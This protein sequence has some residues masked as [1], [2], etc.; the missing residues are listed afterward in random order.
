MPSVER[1]LKD[2]SEIILCLVVMAL[3]VAAF[4]IAAVLMSPVVSWP[5]IGRAIAIV[6]LLGLG[7]IVGAGLLGGRKLA[8]QTVLLA[9][10]GRWM[11][12][13]ANFNQFDRTGWRQF[14]AMHGHSWKPTFLALFF[15]A[16]MIFGPDWWRE[17]N[18]SNLWISILL[19]VV[20]LI[21]VA[22]PN[23]LS[24]RSTR[25]YRFCKIALWLG[26]IALTVFIVVLPTDSAYRYVEHGLYRHLW[27]F[28]GVTLLI[29]LVF[30]EIFA[31]GLFSNYKDTVQQESLDQSGL[32][33]DIDVQ[34]P[35][36]PSDEALEALR[37]D[38]KRFGRSLVKAPVYHLMEILFFLSL[39]VLLVASNDT[40][41]RWAF[42]SGLV[43]W[44]LYAMGEMHERLAHLLSSL[45]RMFFLGGQLV[46]SLV[47]IVLAT[48]RLFDNSYIATVVEGEGW[49]LLNNV[50]LLGYVFS[51]YGVFWLYEYWVNRLL[52]E[53]LIAVIKGGSE[54]CGRVRINKLQD[55]SQILLQIHGGS[56][57]ACVTDGQIRRTYGRM[58]LLD[59]L[60]EGKDQANKEICLVLQHR[61]R[62]YF[63]ALSLVLVIWLAVAGFLYY[64]L[65]QRAEIEVSTTNPDPDRLFD[66]RAALIAGNQTAKGAACEEHVIVLAASGGGTRAALYTYSVLRGLRQVD[67]EPGCSAL[68]RVVLLSGVSGGSAALAYFKVNRQA[69]LKSRPDNKSGNPWAKFRASMAE[70]FIQDVL[71]GASEMR[72]LHGCKRA[73]T[74]V[75]ETSIREGIR[76]SSLLRESFDRRLGDGFFKDGCS[77]IETSQ[78]TDPRYVL[79]VESPG[80][81][82]GL[83]FNSTLGGRF[84]FADRKAEDPCPGAQRRDGG[85]TWPI[86][87]IESKFEPPGTT[88][89]GKGGR[90]VF[91]NLQDAEAL[92]PDPD[93]S[94][95]NI[96]AGP[97]NYVVIKDPDVP[98]ATAAALSA[99]FP[100]V[101]P[102]AAV[103][104]GNLARYWVTDGG[105]ADNRGLV[106]LLYAL[107]GAI[108]RLPETDAGPLPTLHILSADAS[109]SDLSYAQDRG[110]G[111]ALGAAERFASQL[112]T[113][114]LN[115][116]E[117]SYKDL[118]S[119]SKVR[120]HNLIMPLALRSNGGVGTHWMLPNT[121]LL[122][123]PFRGTPQGAEESLDDPHGMKNP[124][125]DKDGELKF[126]RSVL[127][128][129][130]LREPACEVDRGEILTV[131]D[132]L[133]E[134]D[135]E[136][137]SDAYRRFANKSPFA[138]NWLCKP[139]PA[140]K[141]QLRHVETWTGLVE[142]L[143]GREAPAG[144]CPPDAQPAI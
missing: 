47:V 31:A 43:T 126:P 38:W 108:K 84:P 46:V 109:A 83:I 118:P 36:E 88:S 8:L 61:V 101:F 18:L 27:Q 28:L 40:M 56:R 49:G 86:S 26:L 71:Q 34:L 30:A 111:S 41:V 104:R 103:D 7:L 22:V 117:N 110:V 133:H 143:T 95:S 74:T 102:N 3:C 62:F 106:S 82:I 70:P 2:L 66:L 99:N 90:L 125:N 138:V 14:V 141:P 44:I 65:P 50:T 92:F 37:I 67:L 76:L 120:F 63:I 136:K 124:C 64:G 12:R 97:L 51:S 69:L 87:K 140:T 60:F 4:I 123:S 119:S 54:T 55:I 115:E 89:L 128:F 57:F 116:I 15:A 59:R 134:S 29:L 35:D 42:Y 10:L 94:Q 96:S 32:P 91:T 6:V 16:V 137:G 23:Y 130:S 20:A 25:L 45:R 39:P 85:C 131:F 80:K 144:Y 114:K 112:I 129:L 13:I 81:G 135:G 33:Q 1:V 53:R 122:R 132:S 107:E 79:G 5:P 127:R 68:H 72:M 58:K 98:L 105:A 48:G 21:L 139:P 11:D 77:S 113:D 24:C 17:A 93:G 73:D 142:D 9:K 75:D 19:F 121:I 100:P 78:G 52:N